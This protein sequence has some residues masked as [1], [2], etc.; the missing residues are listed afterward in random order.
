M[1][2]EDGIHSV[3]SLMGSLHQALAAQ[4][5]LQALVVRGEISDFRRSSAGHLYFALKDERSEIRCVMFALAAT[6]V[7]FPPSNGLQVVLHGGIELYGQRGQLQLQVRRMRPD[8]EGALRLRLEE[9]R[10]RLTAEGLFEPARKRRLPLLPV[11]VGVVTSRDGA[12][13]RDIA[14]TLKRRNPGVQLIVSP[15]P[16]QGADAPGRLVRALER[17]VAF[18]VD[19]VIVAR[20][21]GSLEDLMAFNDEGL[22]RAVAACSVPVVSA[23]GHETDVTLCDMAADR[24]AAT[25]TAAAELVAADRGELL[26]TL[27]QLRTRLERAL[28]RQLDG[29]RQRLERLARSPVLRFPERL[30]QP[31]RTELGGLSAKLARVQMVRVQLERVLL[32]GL[33]QAVRARHPSLVLG[34]ERA[35]LE[36]LQPRLGA[37]LKRGLALQRERL[38]G[39]QHSLRP[40]AVALARQGLGALADRLLRGSLSLVRARRAELSLLVVPPLSLAPLR[41]LLSSLEARLE[42]AVV[43]DLERRRQLLGA[44]AGQL[45]AL[46]PLSVLHRGYALTRDE[47]GRLVR[48][49]AGRVPGEALRVHLCDGQLGVRVEE[50]APSHGP[51]DELAT[52]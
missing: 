8:G 24:R 21:G 26:G 44:L 49:V 16:V 20:G 5:A 34:R 1:K 32:E 6:Q 48:S 36:E 22:V 4:P 23:I 42:G 33:T 12:V 9:L 43:H 27:E 28:F 14:T 17:V 47:Q 51:G 52:G 45:D 19:C 39:L 46:S 40:P 13:L 35:R 50:I 10:A 3:T 29:Q 37:A 18:G 31:A 15:A 2:N 25:P 41:S 38:A 11:R 7:R 30:V